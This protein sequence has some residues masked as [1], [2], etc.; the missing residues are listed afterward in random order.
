MNELGK[1]G[2]VAAF[3]YVAAAALRLARFNTQVGI[4]DKRYFQGLPSPAA[5]GVLASFVWIMGDASLWMLWIGMRVMANTPIRS[6]RIPDDVYDL[7][8]ARAVQDGV[9]L[10]SVIV[11]LLRNYCDP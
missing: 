11:D 7:A 4:A 6:F 1:F 9:S 10:A 5:A 2:W 3:I 8:M